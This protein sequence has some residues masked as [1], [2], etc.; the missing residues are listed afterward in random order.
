MVTK[1]KKTW[2]NLGAINLEKIKNKNIIVA[3][4]GGADSMVLLELIRKYGNAQNIVVAHVHHGIRESAT[5]DENI[6]DTYCRK[7]K[8]PLEVLRIDAK[9]WAK[10]AKMTLEEYARK[11]RQDFFVLVAKKYTSDIII[12]AH[13][14]DDQAETI[15]YRITKWTSITGLV[16]IEEYARN[17][18]RPLI[19][20][21]KKD[22]L[23]Y[24]KKNNIPYG[25]DETN[26]DTTIP[27]NLLR[28]HVVPQLEKINPEITIAMVRLSNSARE[29][30][31][32][33]DAFFTEVIEKKSFSLDWYHGLPLG[34]QHELL[35][36]I[37]EQ[38]N[39]STHGLSTALIEELDRFLS[40]RNGGKKEI[41]KMKLEKKQGKVIFSV[42]S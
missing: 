15:I 32:S 13:H 16:G 22:I 2:N 23:E 40:T 7:Y 19:S 12:T 3:C 4:S 33:F 9:V 42:I 21:K 8:I 24:A 39:G 11:V 41:K 6:V 29:L 20:V 26:D 30:K 37:Y 27:R 31:M 10:K 17:Y 14:A 25:H 18:I 35:R 36:L 34:F 5:R 38:T 28:H 1:K